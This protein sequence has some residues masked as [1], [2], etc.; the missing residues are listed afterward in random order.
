[1]NRLV[2]IV[3]A[4]LTGIIVASAGVTDLPKR[5]IGT[6]EFYCYTVGKA[7]T[8]YGISR[9]LDIPTT[10]ITRHNPG[11]VDGV[12]QHDILYFPVEEYGAPS[13][14]V[15]EPEAGEP[16]AVTAPPVKPDAVT[17]DPCPEENASDGAEEVVAAPAKQPQVLLSMNLEP[18]AAERSR[19][20]KNALE[21]YRGVL[22]GADTLARRP[23]KV[24]FVLEQNVPDAEAM[25]P[26][27]VMIP[28]DEEAY[29]NAAAA[30]SA[31]TDTYVLNLFSIR[32]SSYLTCPYVI[33]ANIPQAQMYRKAI[34]YFMQAYEGYTPVILRNRNGRNEKEG[35]TDALIRRC[36]NAGI[37]VR[38]IEYEGSL[39]GQLL[40]DLPADAD[41][42]F[43]PSSGTASEF[44]RFAP[45]FR[46]YRRLR[47][48]VSENATVV[49]HL[50]ALFGYPDWVAFRGELETTLHELD[51]TVYSR[52][53]DNYS[54]FDSRGVWDSYVKWYGSTPSESVPSQMLLGFDASMYVIKNIRAN[55]GVFS[56]AYPREYRGVQS[57]F[58]LERVDGGGW[59]NTALYIVNFGS[60]LRTTATL[61]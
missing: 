21:F 30:L 13:A 43:V 1:M 39:T 57:S 27:A 51:A 40:E 33:Q 10:D 58:R 59:V 45:A 52:F 46:S 36:E 14:Q 42:V 41:Y 34:D 22:I 23:G 31:T 32:D 25:A 6:R 8:V 20:A 16:V 9:R 44:L 17:P 60:D 2:H 19:S 49:P 26:A 7:E 5:K 55:D 24:D 4:L 3:A 56:P 47:G 18:G 28:S 53:Y 12:A 54:S 11:A 37:T 38:K 61:I 48:A 35:F 15:A 50:T 29:L